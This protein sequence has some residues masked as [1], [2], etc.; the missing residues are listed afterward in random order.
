MIDK[1]KLIEM[2]KDYKKDR[3]NFIIP[4]AAIYYILKEINSGK[5]DFRSKS[6]QPQISNFLGEV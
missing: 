6:E 1:E 5:C 2:L 3:K 4:H